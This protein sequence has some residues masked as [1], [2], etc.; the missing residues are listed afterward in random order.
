[1][2]KLS[3]ARGCSERDN[4]NNV[5]KFKVFAKQG[6]LELAHRYFVNFTFK[7]PSF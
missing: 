5:K 7:D 2:R 6:L 1:M 3:A 4:F